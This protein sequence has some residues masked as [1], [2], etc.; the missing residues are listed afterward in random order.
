MPHYKVLDGLGV[1]VR[2]T[3]QVLLWIAPE[4]WRRCTNW[5]DTLI[6]ASS[7]SFLLY[8]R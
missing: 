8:L 4:V 3:T 7:Y 2:K 5:Y 1:L 6:T